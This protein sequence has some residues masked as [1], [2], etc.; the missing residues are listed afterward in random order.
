[1]MRFEREKFISIFLFFFFLLFSL[2]FFF[3]VVYSVFL[4]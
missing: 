1:V 2:A 4:V 3:W